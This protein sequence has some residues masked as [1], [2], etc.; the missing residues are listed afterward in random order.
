VGENYLE[1]SQRTDVECGN[2]MA[3][4]ANAVR[5]VLTGEASSVSLKYRCHTPDD[6]HW[7]RLMVSPLREGPEKGAVVMHVDITELEV[8]N[9]AWRISEERLRLAML[10]GKLG[11]ID[12]DMKTNRFDWNSFHS[13]LYG[14]PAESQFPKEFRHALERIAP[15]DVPEVVRQLG[16]ARKS[17]KD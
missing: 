1:A 13:E 3:T 4:V 2:E 17:H 16:Q 14:N 12:L 10:S 5:R 6:Q 11:T 9:E 8:A 7:F 15:E